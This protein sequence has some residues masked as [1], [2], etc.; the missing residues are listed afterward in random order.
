MTDTGFVRGSSTSWSLRRWEALR[1]Y[2]ERGRIDVRLVLK[3]AGWARIERL[4]AQ[5]ARQ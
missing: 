4:D 5:E 1:T 2:I 3:I